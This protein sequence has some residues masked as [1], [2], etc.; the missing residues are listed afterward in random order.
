MF[1]YHKLPFRTRLSDV[2]IV[3]LC[4]VRA[5]YYQL[6]YGAKVPC[7]RNSS[8]DYLECVKELYDTVPIKWE[9]GKPITY[10]IY[11]FLNLCLRQDL[12]REARTFKT[13]IL[14]TM[15]YRVFITCALLLL[16]GLTPEGTVWDY[17]SLHLKIAGGM[18][19]AASGEAQ[20]LSQIHRFIVSR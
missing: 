11:A 5:G 10:G 7:F 18:A 13:H 20:L 2:S 6:T 12:K 16:C 4:L 17:S 14:Y 15:W 1:S 3:P 8:M 19:V 9:P